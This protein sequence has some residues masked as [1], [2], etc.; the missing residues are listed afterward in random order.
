MDPT[1]VG[2]F[3]TARARCSCREGYDCGHGHVDTIAP[4]YLF[5]LVLP[6]VRRFAVPCLLLSF[7]AGARAKHAPLT[8][9]SDTIA[10]MPTLAAARMA[11]AYA[12]SLVVAV[13]LARAALV[14]GVQWP[15]LGRPSP[16]ELAR[17]RATGDPAALARCLGRQDELAR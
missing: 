7:A 1:Q 15:T 12:A 11:A 5:G 10:G 9:A 13:V 8:A 17:V 16:S 4:G 3:A 2:A 14:G 6:F